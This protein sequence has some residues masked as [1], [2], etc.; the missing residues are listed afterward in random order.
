[1]RVLAFSDVRNWDG[2]NRLVD[3]Y[4]PDIVA[5][6]GD[7]TSDG[8]AHFWQD[9]LEEI[10]EFKRE[11]DALTCKGKDDIYEFIERLREL[12]TRYK[13]TQAFLAARKRMHVDKF[14][15]FLRYAGGKCQVVIVKGDHDDDFPGDYEPQRID[16]IPNCREISG[17]TFTF[18]EW[19]FLGLG[20]Q[21]AGYRRT[22]R[23]IIADFK[24]RVGIVIAHAPQKNVRLITELRPRLLI[25]GHYGS[26]HG[27]I[28]GI[29]AAFTSHEHAI[30]EIGRTGAARVRG[31]KNV[32]TGRA[33]LEP[34]A[35]LLR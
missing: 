22:L 6:G 34:A 7:L 15:D 13:R 35:P 26:G 29:P 32:H 2:Y 25:R 5:L 4:E 11:K 31:C 16:E 14:Y 3:R 24:G 8:A 12:K 18:G 9:S 20:F 10:P 30:I 21:Q 28:D 23:S 19:T 17:K 27:L 1:M 33:A